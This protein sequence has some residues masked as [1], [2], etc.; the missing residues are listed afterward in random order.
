M[1][2]KPIDWLVIHKHVDSS[3]VDITHALPMPGGA[4]LRTTTA[5]SR[6][7]HGQDTICVNMAYIP[8]VKIGEPEDADEFCWLEAL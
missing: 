6:A 2:K 4:L 1:N 3:Y 8:G 7:E 5:F